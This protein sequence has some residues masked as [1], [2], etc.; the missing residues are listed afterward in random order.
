MIIKAA[1]R[2]VAAVG[3]SIAAVYDAAVAG[4]AAAAGS[5]GGDR[6]PH[7]LSVD[8]T[9]PGS[10]CRRCWRPGQGGRGEVWGKVLVVAQPAPQ[11]TLPWWSC[12]S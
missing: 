2:P 1:A 3:A 9:G 12:S 7:D 10:I 4:I 8:G 11:V 6:H 5:P